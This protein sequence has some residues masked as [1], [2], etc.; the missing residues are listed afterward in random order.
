TISSVLDI[1]KLM[2]GESIGISA[3]LLLEG[4]DAR[5]NHRACVRVLRA[6]VFRW[7][8]HSPEGRARGGKLESNFRFPG[9]H[10]PEEHHLAFLLFL[11]VLVLHVDLTTACQARLQGYQRT[12]GV[13]GQRG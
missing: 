4:G 2:A 7:K 5:G 6:P 9:S 10:W 3:I 1:S 12:M 13:D 11:G 8:D